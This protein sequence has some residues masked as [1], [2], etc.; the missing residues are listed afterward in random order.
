M[1]GG[2]HWDGKDDECGMRGGGAGSV[3]GATRS[4][5]NPPSPF[6]VSVVA[7]CHA[8]RAT[9]DPQFARVVWHFYNRAKY[10]YAY[11]S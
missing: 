1:C 6:L 11:Q 8:L 2:V 7:L 4:A 9:S 5:H 3:G 10:M